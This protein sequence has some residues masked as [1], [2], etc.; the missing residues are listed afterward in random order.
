MLLHVPHNASEVMSD[1]RHS[2]V[3][4]R[5]GTFATAP[6][7]PLSMLVCRIK[8]AGEKSTTLFAGPC[9]SMGRQARPVIT[10]RELHVGMLVRH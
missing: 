7:I 5:N 9:V 1:H 10:P 4:H 8:F 3:G 6:V 2:E